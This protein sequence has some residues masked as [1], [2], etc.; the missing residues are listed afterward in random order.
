MD[1]Y[2]N[3]NKI[4]FTL[5]G[6]KTAG[7]VQRA[8]NAELA[9]HERVMV[10]FAVDGDATPAA[11]TRPV[12]AIGE[13]RVEMENVNE[14]V[15]ATL[16]GVSE[17]FDKLERAV[18][19]I[20]GFAAEQ[21]AIETGLVRKDVAEGLDW[22]CRAM[23]TSAALLS[24]PG[25]ELPALGAE[26]AAVTAMLRGAADDAAAAQVL[27][28]QVRPLLPRLR[29]Q[30]AALTLAGNAG[31]LRRRRLHEEF[32]KFSQ[33]LPQLAGAFRQTAV[34]LQTGEEIK[35]LQVFQEA[36]SELQAFIALLQEVQRLGETDF[37]TTVFEDKSLAQWVQDF[38][39]NLKSIV[40]TFGNR[41][42]V[43][44]ADLLEYEMA[45]RLERWQR[46]LAVLKPTLPRAE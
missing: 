41:D 19:E 5:N 11:L 17:Y 28:D 36:V 29:Q 13:V 20:G 12:A 43:L 37:T 39:E 1:I 24:V 42:Y 45:P 26:V 46:I 25:N 4:D 31:T 2:I 44:L 6:E 40:D 8:L 33:Q 14:L 7:E 38:L 15:Q 30:H 18:N 32:E 23:S 27:R 3:G 21:Q 34:H 35:G 22:V 10:S 9:K 16:R